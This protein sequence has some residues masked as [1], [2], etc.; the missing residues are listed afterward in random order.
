MIIF[1]TDLYDGSGID[2]GEMRI[3]TSDDDGQ[4]WSHSGFVA[5]YKAM[6]PGLF[7][8]DEERFLAFYPEYG[9][10]PLAQA[11]YID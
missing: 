1:S 5:P 7:V 8:L 9:D 11:A 10:Q 4:S 2:E 6:W 3:I